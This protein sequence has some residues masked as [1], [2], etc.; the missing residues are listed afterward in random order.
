MIT[1]NIQIISIVF[2]LPVLNKSYV[3]ENSTYF[4]VETAPGVFRKESLLGLPKVSASAS[5]VAIYYYSKHTNGVLVDLA[6]A[7]SLKKTDFS[8]GKSTIFCVHGWQNDHSSEINNDVRSA[9]LAVQDVNFFVVDWSK[10]A[11]KDYVTAQHNVQ[12]IGQTLGGLIKDASA[13]SGLNLGKTILVGHSLGAHVAG[14]AGKTIGSQA[15]HIVGK[16]FKH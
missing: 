14:V 11:K 6:D 16:F 4:L 15:D 10:I 1:A 7:N 9:Y 12:S 8:S 2:L 5:D 3:L 13:H